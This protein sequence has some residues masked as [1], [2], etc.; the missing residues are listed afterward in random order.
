MGTKVSELYH[1]PERMCLEGH[2]VVA[3]FHDASCGDADGV[4]PLGAAT[5][6][7]PQ[8]RKHGGHGR[9]EASPFTPYPVHLPRTVVAKS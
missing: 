6:Q 7:Y 5:S 2:N 1:R 9:R 8:G 4:R 3:N